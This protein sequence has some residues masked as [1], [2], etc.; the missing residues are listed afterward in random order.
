MKRKNE[1][2]WICALARVFRALWGW[3]GGDV[4]RAWR[5]ETKSA[6]R[7]VGILT[8]LVCQLLPARADAS[9]KAHKA[10]GRSGRAR[11][12][13]RSQKTETENLLEHCAQLRRARFRGF[14]VSS[15]QNVSFF[16]VSS[17][18]PMLER[19]QRYIMKQRAF[20]YV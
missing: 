3:A 8:R 10:S 20:I 4:A 17:R 19:K 12:R 9:T 11:C 13:G 5:V 14:V 1:C 6:I 15:A 2:P 7:E 18:I 16:Y